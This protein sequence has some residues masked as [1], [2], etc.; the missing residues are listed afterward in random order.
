[1]PQ[2]DRRFRDTH[3]VDGLTLPGAINK[4]ERPH[5]GPAIVRVRDDLVE[6]AEGLQHSHGI[7]A[8][9]AAR[10]ALI[11]LRQC[12]LEDRLLPRTLTDAH[13]RADLPVF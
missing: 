1:M 11:C 9:V 5:R 7:G 2:G 12:L 4:L 13:A 3:S 10:A 6:Y 8:C